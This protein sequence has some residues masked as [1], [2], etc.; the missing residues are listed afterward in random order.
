[1]YTGQRNYI[2]QIKYWYQM[3]LPGN[4]SNYF[5][6]KIHNFKADESIKKIIERIIRKN[7]TTLA[8]AETTLYKIKWID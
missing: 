7:V 8:P 6:I 4:K 2:E 5:N 3:Q 1:M